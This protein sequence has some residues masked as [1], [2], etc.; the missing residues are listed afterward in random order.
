MG[1]L[2]KITKISVIFFTLAVLYHKIVTS[3]NSFQ[4]NT[5][6]TKDLYMLINCKITLIFELKKRIAHI[7]C[8]FKS[9]KK[10]S[11]IKCCPLDKICKSFK[12][13]DNF[14]N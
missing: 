7:K 5:S 3:N 13:R 2:F 11:F 10:N 1:N 14:S 6:T 9:L 8:D 4:Q 12:N